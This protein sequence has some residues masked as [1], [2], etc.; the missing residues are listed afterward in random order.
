EEEGGEI[1]GSVVFEEIVGEM[2]RVTIDANVVDFVP[3]VGS[4]WGWF[5]NIEEKMVCM[6]RKRDEFMKNVIE[7]CLRRREGGAGGGGC[8]KKD[9]IQVLMDL[10]KKESEYYT[11]EAIR[12]L[13]LVLVQGAT[14]TTS[15]TLEWALSLL[16]KNPAILQ[17]A[18][19]QIE[20]HTQNKRLITLS[21]LLEIPYLR[22]IINETLRMHPAAP[23]LTPHVSSEKCT[24]GRFDIPR[25]TIL[26]VNAWDIQNN[27]E[28]WEEPEKFMPE[29]F[30]GDKSYE[31]KYFPFGWGRRACPGENMAMNMVGIVLGCLIQC[32]DW[33]S[34]GEI[35]MSEGRGV[36]TEKVEPLCVKFVPRDFVLDFFS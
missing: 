29:R 5:W 11:D 23:L 28:I 19:T 25:G 16:L 2:A 4:I 33:E 27:S 9:L 31:F 20:N 10:Q 13:L 35:V 3:F 26:L 34:V 30:E 15:T 7:E 36:I 18:R 17:K 21:D 32:F 1:G 22:C 8:G 14:H 12:N 6:Q 24:I